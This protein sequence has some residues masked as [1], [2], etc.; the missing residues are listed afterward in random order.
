MISLTSDLQVS[1]TRGRNWSPQSYGLIWADSCHISPH[2][3]IRVIRWAISFSK[4]CYDPMINILMI[5]DYYILNCMNCTVKMTEP[6]VPINQGRSL[7]RRLIKNLLWQNSMSKLRWFWHLHWL[8]FRQPNGRR[9][10][11]KPSTHW[12]E[13][14]SCPEGRR[15]HG[16]TESEAFGRE[17]SIIYF[18]EHFSGCILNRRFM[19]KF[20]I[21]ELL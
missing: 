9:A 18:Y 1:L 4:G 3:L 2:L 12:P 20:V 8:I 13:W 21:F 14:T 10:W 5:T 17:N 15:I 16:G 11:S 7:C 6:H 19:V